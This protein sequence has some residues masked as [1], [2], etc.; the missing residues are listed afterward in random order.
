MLFNELPQ[1]SFWKQARELSMHLLLRPSHVHKLF[2]IDLG[3]GEGATVGP[4]AE[5]YQ[6]RRALQVS[7]G[8]ILKFS[9]NHR[10]RGCSGYGQWLKVKHIGGYREVYPS[11]MASQKNDELCIHDGLD[12]PDP[13]S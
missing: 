12:V 1:T 9:C 7:F 2:M 3:W 11:L 13:L 5:A 6:I 4:Q 10:A 8:N